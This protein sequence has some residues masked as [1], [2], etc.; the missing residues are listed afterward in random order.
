MAN[1]SFCGWLNWT[2]SRRSSELVTGS[3]F[4]ASTWSPC[5]RVTSPAPCS[6]SVDP[7]QFAL[8]HFA[9]EQRG[10]PHQAG[11]DADLREHFGGVKQFS[12]GFRARLFPGK[13][14]R[15]IHRQIAEE[16]AARAF[17]PGGAGELEFRVRGQPLQHDRLQRAGGHAGNPP[18]SSRC[19]A[20]RRR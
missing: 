6:C 10:L 1:W 2:T 18:R 19:F 20:S 9:V 5:T 16:V 12:L 13:I 14:H 7:A 11:A 4:H 3:T 15:A 8:H 17:R